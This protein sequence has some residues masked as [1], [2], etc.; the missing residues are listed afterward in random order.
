MTRRHVQHLLLFIVFAGMTLFSACRPD[1][2]EN[3]L[4]AVPADALAVAN[5]KPESLLKATGVSRESAEFRRA[6]E[7]L[8]DFADLSDSQQ[9]RFIELINSDSGIGSVQYVLMY[10]DGNPMI[11]CKIADH[12]KFINQFDK[13]AWDESEAHDLMTWKSRE[14]RLGI[15]YATD[16]GVALII[17]NATE[18]KSGA[19]ALFKLNERQKSKPL[20]GWQRERLD[21][22][23]AASVLLDF[24]SMLG[25]DLA[26]M[27]NSQYAT[28]LG[29]DAE[30][31]AFTLQADRKQ[32]RLSV[33]T[34]NHDGKA[35]ALFNPDLA[36]GTDF[37]AAALL[38]SDLPVALTLGIPAERFEQFIPK[39]FRNDPA[40]QNILRNTK[41]VALGVRSLSELPSPDDLLE[42]DGALAIR[43]T[44]GSN[45]GNDLMH[46]FLGPLAGTPLP[47]GGVRYELPY[48]DHALY[49][50]SRSDALLVSSQ[51]AT[52]GNASVP[53]HDGALAL[54]QYRLPQNGISD[55]IGYI[56]ADSA[57][58]TL[59][60][61][62]LQQFIKYLQ[63]SKSNP[64][65]D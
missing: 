40:I 62:D 53:N 63:Q 4:D 44:P 10:I 18:A 45:V 47:D 57:E 30:Y 38:P 15:G 22:D 29:K 64:F 28:L 26:S 27:A 46:M 51:P 32:A 61:T 24:K 49:C 3:L 17:F 58:F 41:S 25:I 65:D 12:E 20:P 1:K 37:S 56:K 36:E 2:T 31:A 6:F 21:G 55:G 16:P 8:L 60:F 33:S 23:Q 7:Y 43:F 14:G 9:Q 39:M 34:L 35:S 52:F 19:N 50:Y 59:N 5:I 48:S 54:I 42:L 11:L 13:Q